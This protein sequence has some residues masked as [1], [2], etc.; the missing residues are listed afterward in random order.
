M[1]RY[2]NRQPP[3]K[4]DVLNNMHNSIQHENHVLKPEIK[5]DGSI[6]KMCCDLKLSRLFT[7]IANYIQ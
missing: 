3:R 4:I 1:N 2:R 5:N 6:D 7:W